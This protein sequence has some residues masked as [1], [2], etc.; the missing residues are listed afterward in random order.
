MKTPWLKINPPE[1][2]SPFWWF[3]WVPAIVVSTLILYFLYVVGS[4][5]LVPVLASFALAY[6]LNP[7]FYQAEKRGMSR[8][9]SAVVAI[10]LVTVV[11]TAF[12]AYVIPDLWAE[13]S[14]AG[15]RISENFTPE[16]AARQRVFLK[17]YSPA[18]EKVAGDKI[19]KFLSEPI[20]F[21][22]ENISASTTVDETGNVKS[23]SGGSSAI[24]TVLSSG[25]DL[26]LVPFFVFYILIDFQKWRD[27]LE[28]L[29]PPRFREPFSRLFDESGRILESYVRG[30]ILIGSIMAV[31]YAVGFYFLGV[32][33]WA[34]I[35]MIA[36][37]LNAV[38]YVGTIS[39]IILACGFSFAD[40][41]TFGHLAAIL[42][43]FAAVQS[44]EGY[45]L[46]PRIMGDRLNLHPMAVFL[47]LLVGGKL[48]GL[49]GVVMAIP[50]I[51]IAK[52]FFKFLREL[53]QA[54]YFYHV[55]DLHPDEAPSE[56]IEER[57]ADAADT[58][59]AE[60]EQKGKEDEKEKAQ[61]T[62][63]LP[64]IIERPA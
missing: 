26:F 24:L 29:I 47:G 32:P 59:L 9:V 17:R 43:V 58:V 51:A 10:L 64:P 5:A 60:Q 21:Y 37:L 27:S 16:N 25:F 20:A 54:S 45:Y 2:R 61:P 36:G 42:G 3:R 12:L 30:Q 6:L 50:A 38:P 28:D 57:I 1:D 62:G 49:L 34:G 41:A 23:T 19:E 46:T 40:G 44:L 35:A 14:K 18:L 15:A 8:M 52:V 31:C 53:Y 7:I 56:K 39:G 4:V 22:N 11:I 33:A 55:G 13:T 63:E 48:F